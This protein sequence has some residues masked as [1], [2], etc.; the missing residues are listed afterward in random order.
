MATN[1]DKHRYRYSSG[2]SAQEQ[3]KWGR[4]TARSRYGMPRYQDGNSPQ[5][6]DRSMPQRLGDSAGA[7]ARPAGSGWTNDVSGWTRGARGEPQMHSESAEG[8]PNFDHRG[9]DGL[10]RKW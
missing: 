7:G 8:K 6:E 4:D 3:E 1:L 2:V 9:P 5:P 10:P